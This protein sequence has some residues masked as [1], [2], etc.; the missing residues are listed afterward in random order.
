MYGTLFRDTKKDSKTS[1]P[2]TGLWNQFQNVT[3]PDGMI[4]LG[5]M[6]VVYMIP[7]CCLGALVEAIEDN[8]RGP[9]TTN[10]CALKKFSSPSISTVFYDIPEAS[11][12]YIKAR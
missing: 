6:L 12:G 8:S 3:T 2:Q 4:C 11:E 7:S 9:G 1:L 5:D 10:L